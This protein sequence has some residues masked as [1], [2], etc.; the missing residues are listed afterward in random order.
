MTNPKRPNPLHTF[1]SLVSELQAKG[2]TL[3][4]IAAQLDVAPPLLSHWL[5]GR[6]R[7]GPAHRDSIAAW[8][9]G[10]MPPSAW[11]NAREAR[12]IERVQSA[13]DSRAA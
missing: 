8:S 6:T 7:P 4:V 11:H 3:T 1:K 2:L 9:G 10:R 5:A 12:R 13:F